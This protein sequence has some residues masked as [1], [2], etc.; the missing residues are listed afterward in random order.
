MRS[1]LMFLLLSLS[2]FLTVMLNETI[3]CVKT[4]FTSFSEIL[5][6]LSVVALI[7]IKYTAVVVSFCKLRIKF[8]CLCKVINCTC[9]LING[10]SQACAIII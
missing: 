1:N 9:K 4:E 3:G 5:K 6:T 8:N 7:C 2:S 10:G